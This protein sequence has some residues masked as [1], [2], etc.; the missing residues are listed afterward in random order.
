M[1]EPGDRF[2]L[3][4]RLPS[5]W[6]RTTASVDAVPTFV[7]G[8]YI[9]GDR[10]GRLVR[11]SGDSRIV[12]EKRLDSLGGI[13]RA[14]VFLPALPSH[15][16]AITEDGQA[17]LVEAESGNLE[18]PWPLN[19]PPWQ[20]P[21]V[22]GEL[23]S[24]RFADGRVARWSARL[25]PEIEEHDP[26]QP[27][28]VE[29]EAFGP[30]AGLEVLRRRSGTELTLRSPWSPWQVTVE[31]Q[32]FVVQDTRKPGP[33]FRTR[34]EE[35]WAYVAWEAPSAQLPNGRLWVSDNTGVRGFEPQ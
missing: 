6:W 13:A 3:M 25:K 19:T 33:A 21:L 20:G 11:M 23:V 27:K 30:S 12:W 17:W 14:P 29:G 4:S 35:P 15:M 28:R 2:A 31:E 22:E 18:G 26:A 5:L 8:D 1:R 16:L 24:V 10:D 7:G 34:L 9:L 32:N